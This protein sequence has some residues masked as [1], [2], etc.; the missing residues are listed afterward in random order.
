MEF[1]IYIE[2]HGKPGKF[3]ENSG[4]FIWNSRWSPWLLQD[5]VCANTK[6]YYDPPNEAGGSLCFC[7]VRPA[8]VRPEGKK[9]WSK[10]TFWGILSMFWV[11]LEIST[12]VRPS[13]HWMGYVL[14]RELVLGFWGL[15]PET[16]WKWINICLSCAPPIL[17]VRLDRRSVWEG[18][19]LRRFCM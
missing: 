17:D 8:S 10:N 12:S 7:L 6:R 3:R 11:F 5:V 19:E 1:P 15:E 2:D 4:K 16:N 18:S 14:C 9:I 13:G